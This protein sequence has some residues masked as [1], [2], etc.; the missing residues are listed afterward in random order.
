MSLT[1]THKWSYSGNWQLAAGSWD[2]RAKPCSSFINI[3]GSGGR[4][5][6][7]AHLLRSEENDVE[8]EKGEREKETSFLSHFTQQ[9]TEVSLGSTTVSYPHT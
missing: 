4:R 6:R 7:P 8:G 2:W 3:D 9:F 1:N 5:R